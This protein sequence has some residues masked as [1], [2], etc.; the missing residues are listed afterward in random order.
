[1][2]PFDD[3]LDELMGN[4]AGSTYG[5]E[6]RLSTE[7]YDSL[8]EIL[9]NRDEE[10][11]TD[12]LS[13]ISTAFEDTGNDSSTESNTEESNVEEESN[14]E[15]S[16]TGSSEGVSNT[17][18]EDDMLDFLFGNSDAEVENT[19]QQGQG[20][21]S[22]SSNTPRTRVNARN[23][24]SNR[25]VRAT[26]RAVDYGLAWDVYA[27][28]YSTKEVGMLYKTSSGS[29]SRGIKKDGH[30]MRTGG[31]TRAMRKVPVDDFSVDL[32]QRIKDRLLEKYGSEA[33]QNSIF[34]EVFGKNMYELTLFEAE[35]EQAQVEDMEER[36]RVEGVSLSELARRLESQKTY[37]SKERSVFLNKVMALHQN[38]KKYATDLF[39][40]VNV[41]VGAVEVGLKVRYENGIVLS[42]KDAHK[43]DE[44]ALGI[45]SVTVVVNVAEYLHES[46]SR[47]VEQLRNRFN[48]LASANFSKDGQPVRVTNLGSRLVVGLDNE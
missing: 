47:E 41:T 9:G 3:I 15:E 19:P 12:Y 48:T 20:N 42:V 27:L 22:A 8:V 14:T 40:D 46:F 23:T 43:V 25:L 24:G 33:E 45:G 44:K 6:P 13:R 35:D 29:V 5:V 4:I 2:N 16:N 34:Y 31:Q 21:S 30:T 11:V 37:V 1:M 7:T 18:E 39:G 38:I 17:T 32:V 28:G 26:G 36:A 10:S